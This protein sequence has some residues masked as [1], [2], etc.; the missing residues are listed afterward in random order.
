M[1]IETVKA[2]YPKYHNVVSSWRTHLMA[3]RELRL[4]PTLASLDTV[5]AVAASLPCP[6]LTDISTNSLSGASLNSPEDIFAIWDQLYYESIP[7]GR[8]GI[9]MMALSGVDLALWDALGKAERRPVAGLI[10]GI[11]KPSIEV[12][13]TGLDSEWYAELGVSGQKLTHRW[14]GTTD[15]AVAS[16]EAARQI[17]G[18][19]ARLMFD[20]YMSWD[21]DVAL[22]M[23][24]ALAEFRYLLVRR[25]AHT[26]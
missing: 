7:Y 8:K 13:A 18:N 4:E 11:R 25:R 24:D 20:V 2:V 19:D 5:T 14:N 12:Y 1:K 21:A 15:D 10:G 22:K 23:A 9:A 17:M 26:R 16:A 3:D 6:S